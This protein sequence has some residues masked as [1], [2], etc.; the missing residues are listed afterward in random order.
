MAPVGEVGLTVDQIYW[1][2][3][4]GGIEIMQCS[5]PTETFA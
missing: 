4:I 1:S 5:E 2:T 3:A